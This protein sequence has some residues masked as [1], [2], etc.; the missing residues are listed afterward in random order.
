[1]DRHE[2]LHAARYNDYLGRFPGRPN[3]IEAAREI[4]AQASIY[5]TCATGGKPSTR[6]ARET[7][8]TSP[9]SKMIKIHANSAIPE[10]QDL[11]TLKFTENQDSGS[12]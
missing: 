12:F 3:H 5:P 8:R 4:G 6:T 2:T 9:A 1:M 11:K 7:R 10:P